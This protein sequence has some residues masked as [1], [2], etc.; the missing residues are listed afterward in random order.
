[1]KYVLMFFTFLSVCTTA[2]LLQIPLTLDNT[3]TV[4]IP[5]GGTS[6]DKTFEV[7][8]SE[9][10]DF[11]RYLDKIKSYEI[12]LI[13][14]EPSSWS[15]NLQTV[16]NGEFS[17]PEVNNKSY[18][19]SMPLADPS[20][21]FAQNELKD[22]YITTASKLSSSGKMKVNLKGTVSNNTGGEL[23]LKITVKLKVR[24]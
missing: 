19:F 14:I 3:Q 2:D 21:I 1:M 4:T 20:P 15:G 9:D 8:P 13:T 18:K 10:P 6:F 22:L 12:E 23:K 16:V 17:L 5:N 7:K 11:Q 24:V